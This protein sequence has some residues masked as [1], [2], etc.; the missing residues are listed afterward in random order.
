M[1]II[2]YCVYFE[3]QRLLAI[4]FLQFLRKEGAVGVFKKTLIM[5]LLIGGIMGTSHPLVFGD[6]PRLTP[7]KGKGGN[8]L[9][10]E[11]GSVTTYM[12][13]DGGYAGQAMGL[14][15]IT[16]YQDKSGSYPGK[17][18]SFGGNTTIR[19]G[20]SGVHP[21]QTQKMGNIT[22]RTDGKGTTVDQSQTIGNTTIYRGKNRK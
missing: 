2:A 8:Y 19:T 3:K 9:G 10:L 6:D 5:T 1:K 14:D 20:R 15:G 22:I 7:F 13:R 16:I 21:E 17:T 4:A 12:G 18:Q 11:L